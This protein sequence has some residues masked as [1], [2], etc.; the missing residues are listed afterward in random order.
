MPA[1][2]K[3]TVTNGDI[4]V[5]TAGTVIDGLDLHGRIFVD[6]PNV[7]IKNSIIR[8][9]DSGWTGSSALIMAT[10]GYANLQVS[11]VELVPTVKSGWVNGIMG[12]NFTATRLNIHH[13]IDSVHITGDNTIVQRS[14]LHENL[15]F[16][17]D[18]GQRGTPSHD[19]SIQ[20]VGGKNIS[21]RDN[22]I[23]GAFN[24][25][26]Q[27]TQ[28]RST[29]ANVQF[30][31]NVADGGGCTVNIAEKGGGAIHGLVITDNE[32]GRTTKVSN[33]AIIAPISSMPEIARNFYAPDGAAV[34]VHKG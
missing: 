11:D 12:S 1:G 26:V 6:A 30:T 5:K 15:H 8:G 25:G 28:D 17:N 16:K 32:F 10:G 21:I 29:V 34:T 20:I 22:H 13:V 31:G 27:I 18:P 3:L 4:R 2:T 24:S 9:S 14:W 19:D 33:C 7:T 23:S